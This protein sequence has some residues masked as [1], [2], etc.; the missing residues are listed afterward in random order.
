MF[1]FDNLLFVGTTGSLLCWRRN[2]FEVPD[3]EI[4]WLQG[5]LVAGGVVHLSVP[6]SKFHVFEQ[7][8]FST[9]GLL[10]LSVGFLVLELVEVP[11][12]RV[13]EILTQID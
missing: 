8:N 2:G 4:E 5:S 7:A 11:W 9:L 3:K 1:D 12:L 13:Q 6:P 10:D